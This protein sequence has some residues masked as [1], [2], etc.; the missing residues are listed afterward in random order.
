MKYFELL[1]QIDKALYTYQ[2]NIDIIEKDYPDKQLKTLDYKTRKN[3]ISKELNK[4]KSK[5]EKLFASL[6]SEIQYLRKSQPYFDKSLQLQK[7]VMFP[8][9]FIFGRFKIVHDN[10]N[11]RFIPKLIPFPL[12][13]AL[14]SYSED[15]VSYSSI[16]FKSFTN[17]SIK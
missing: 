8:E 9:N 2:V 1:K 14:Y 4:L 15:S 12:E 13:K 3:R 7:R 6:D 10:L 5:L 17:F 16:Y 11:E